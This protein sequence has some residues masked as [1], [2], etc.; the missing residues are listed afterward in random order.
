MRN[1]ISETI[2]KKLQYQPPIRDQGEGR[3]ICG[4]G[5]PLDLKGFTVLPVTLGNTLLWHE[6]GV[7]PYL[8]LEMLIGAD[9]LSSYQCSL[10]Y[11]KNNQK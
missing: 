5:E 1:L 8:P 7:V 3:V 2:Y 4:N 9:V 6:F 10:L 11:S